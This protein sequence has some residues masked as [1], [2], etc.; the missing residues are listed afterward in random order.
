MEEEK[1]FWLHTRERIPK[2]SMSMLAWF[3]DDLTFKT[4][5]DTR[6]FFFFSFQS[7]ILTTSIEF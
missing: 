5:R 2:F 1:D 3:C 6:F 7:F 4:S